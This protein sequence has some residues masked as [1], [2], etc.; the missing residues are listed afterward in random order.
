MTG[1]SM[2]NSDIPSLSVIIPVLNEET[3]LP[4]LLTHLQQE[5]ANPEKLEIIVV[6]GGSTDQS[7]SVVNSFGLRVLNAPKGRARQMNSGARSAKGEVLYFLHADSLPPRHFDSEILGAV[8]RNS[9]AGCF[10]LQFN[11]RSYFLSLFAWFTRFNL[12]ICRGGD[13]SLFI[14]KNLFQSL[15]GFNEEFT[16]YEDNEFIGRIYRAAH[17]KVL[18]KNV[19]TSP[20]KYARNGQFRLQYHFAVVHLK[21]FMGAP[22]QK[23]FSYYN[24]HI[25]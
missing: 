25:R 8:N 16:I 15:G 5:A 1:G 13:Q 21:K 2:R 23:L 6:D 18:A 4:T 17:F 11:S 7:V 24:K 9:Q 3:S 10:R 12:P 22:P 14:T 19:V 20:R